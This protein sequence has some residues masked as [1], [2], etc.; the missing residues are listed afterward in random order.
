M[1][2]SWKIIESNKHT[3]VGP[4]NIKK[5]RCRSPR[6]GK[7][8]DFFVFDS[9]DWVNIIPI[10]KHD[11]I[12]MVRQFRHGCRCVLLE[13]PGGL[14]DNADKDPAETAKRELLEETGYISEDISLISKVFPQPAF[15]NNLG[16]T[17]LAKQVR[18]TSIQKL[19]DAED[20]EV[21]LM[22]LQEI[23]KMLLRG[24][25]RHGQTAMALSLY[26]LMRKSIETKC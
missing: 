17:Y 20:I 9:P 3:Q 21:V 12:V 6:T 24:D 16:M 23:R 1:I 18:K 19:D 25:I 2:K 13:I 14:V 8:H 7:E 10:T 26:L 22:D 5:N 4:F 11:K 15:I